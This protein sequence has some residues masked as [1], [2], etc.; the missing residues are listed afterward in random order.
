[1]KR[2]LNSVKFLTKHEFRQTAIKNI[3]VEEDPEGTTIVATNCFCMGIVKI[4]DRTKEDVSSYLLTP[5]FE[6][7]TI[8]A[9]EFPKWRML[10]PEKLEYV[11]SFSKKE[12]LKDINSFEQD[13]SFHSGNKVLKFDRLRVT[14][15]V[16]SLFRD[17]ELIRAYLTDNSCILF[18]T[19]NE[20]Y[21]KTALL[22]SL[23]R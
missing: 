18:T 21:S 17:R 7:S 3:L 13:V 12:L 11:K 9:T 19:E 22:A 4:K 23:R 1:M 6:L 14:K 15:L 5:S 2:Y 16:K 8:D 10:L 20:K